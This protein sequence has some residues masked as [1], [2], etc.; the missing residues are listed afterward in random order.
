[1]AWRKQLMLTVGV[2]YK[3]SEPSRSTAI[4]AAGAVVV[5]KQL[6]LEEEGEGEGTRAGGWVG[7]E[8]LVAP[9]VGR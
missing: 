5:Q 2:A 1:M 7:L 9:S 8:E 6:L 4:L 3:M